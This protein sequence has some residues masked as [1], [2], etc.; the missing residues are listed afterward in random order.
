[1]IPKKQ[2]PIRIL[3]GNNITLCASLYERNEF[4][5]LAP[6]PLGALTIDASVYNARRGEQQLSYKIVGENTLAI[7]CDTDT[8]SDI[9]VYAL[10]IRAVNPDSGQKIRFAYKSIVQIVEYAEDL[11]SGYDCHTDKQQ[12]YTVVNIPPQVACG[13]VVNF[14]QY[15]VPGGIVTEQELAAHVEV[16]VAKQLANLDQFVELTE[17]VESFDG[18]ITAAQDAANQASAGIQGLEEQIEDLGEQIAPMLNQLNSALGDVTSK[19]GEQGEAIDTL[20]DKAK[21]DYEVKEYADYA[22]YNADTSRPSNTISFVAQD[23]SMWVQ[24]K[25]YSMNAGCYVGSDKAGTSTTAWY[26]A[27]TLNVAMIGWDIQCLGYC[28]SSLLSEG[29]GLFV[30]NLRFNSATDIQ[31]KKFAWL[32]KTG[33]TPELRLVVSES[34]VQLYVFVAGG[35]FRGANIRILA[36]STSANRAATAGARNFFELSNNTTPETTEPVGTDIADVPYLLKNGTAAQSTKVLQTNSVLNKERRVL[37]GGDNDNE[38]YESIYKSK[39]LTYNPTTGEL[40]ITDT[41]SSFILAPTSPWF[42]VPTALWD[43]GFWLKNGDTS[44]GRLIGAKGKESSIEYYYIGGTFTT[45]DFKFNPATK[46]MEGNV[47]G[48]LQTHGGNEIFIGNQGGAGESTNDTVWF[49]Y[50]DA[51]GSQTTNNST[52]LAHY[53][54]GNRKGGHS[55]VYLHAARFKGIADTADKLQT[56]RKIGLANFDGTA[57][58][59]LNSIQ[60][61]FSVRWTTNTTQWQR[62]I[63]L[64][65]NATYNHNTIILA[66]QDSEAIN[67]SGILKFQARTGNTTSTVYTDVKWLALSQRSIDVR[68]S[69]RVYVT[70][71]TDTDEYV[72]IDLYANSA[73]TYVQMIFNVLCHNVNA[74]VS[75]RGSGEWVEVSAITGTLEST[76]TYE[77][78]DELDAIKARLA[79]L[80][81]K[82]TTES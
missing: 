51:V 17:K 58:V 68:K 74:D 16:E 21:N 40:E 28:T 57:D 19:V 24:G 80:E 22:G 37:L 2:E 77:V 29:G 38:E 54:F 18:R 45:P 39:L 48:N 4:G 25:Q 13:G 27:G 81:A 15:I 23:N 63:R 65:T 61:A 72:Y 55:G 3:Q 78:F 67:F 7:N 33:S 12:G 6:L 31:I 53:Y 75:Y 62:V 8:F 66:V 64:K 32:T 73:Y 44:L 10:D 43:R 52:R 26:L 41:S 36:E 50:R 11:Q 5:E 42:K 71:P 59:G 20:L 49:N 76:S 79:A 34:K 46:T 70:R 1:M 60:G 47:L 9:G 82:T 35:R 30:L 69:F 56:A 14:L